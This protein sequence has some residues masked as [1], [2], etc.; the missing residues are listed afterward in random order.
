MT[1]SSPVLVVTQPDDVTADTV[2][3]ELNRR[4]VPVVRLDPGGFPSSVVLSARFG[5]DGLSGTVRTDSRTLPLDRVR[6]VYWRRPSPYATTDPFLPSQ[7]IAWCLE[8]ARYGL[9]GAL[10]ALPG[11]AYVNH[12]FRNRAAEY[13]PAQLATAARCGLPV[14]PTLLTNDPAQAREFARAQGRVVYKPLRATEYADAN[15]TAL[16]VWVDEVEPDGI[17]DGVALTAHLFQRRVPAVADLRLTAVGDELFT[18]RITGSP[19][20]DWRRHYEDLSYERVETPR[21]LVR[22]VREYLRAFGLVFGAFDFGVD[23]DGRPWMYE[24]NPNG[25]WAWFPEPITGRIAAALADR[26]QRPGAYA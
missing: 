24:C 25:Q 3:G 15:G 9:G 16:T 1:G 17:G 21:E 13:K 2:I 5:P 23:G 8:E 18:V 22:G 26:L 11:A 19:G 6:S 20:L 4:N 10:A 7:D 12:P 14:P